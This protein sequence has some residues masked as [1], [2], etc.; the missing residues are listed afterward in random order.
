M[1]G[2]LGAGHLNVVLGFNL[3]HRGCLGHTLSVSSQIF[4]GDPCL[5]YKGKQGNRFNLKS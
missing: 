5:G 3:G 4:L 1:E 2:L